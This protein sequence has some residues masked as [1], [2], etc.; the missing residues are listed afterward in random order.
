MR[1]EEIV[2]R[3]PIEVLMDVVGASKNI[4][5]VTRDN[6]NENKTTQ[7]SSYIIKD[8]KLKFVS[9]NKP[10]FSAFI[11]EDKE[12]ILRE[13]FKRNVFSELVYEFF[14][15]EFTFE[16]LIK[17]SK[18][19]DKEFKGSSTEFYNKYEDTFKQYLF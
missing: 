10:S 1:I 6:N 9:C 19:Y 3:N 14:D 7:V 18:E 15:D 5:I 13:I 12:L 4:I 16:D 2:E 8:D 11:E 17:F